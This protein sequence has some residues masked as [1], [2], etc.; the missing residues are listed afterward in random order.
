MEWKDSLLSTMPYSAAVA[1]YGLMP[2]GPTRG[3][4]EEGTPG[5]GLWKKCLVKRDLLAE[6]RL[7]IPLTLE[8]IRP[9]HVCN[10]PSKSDSGQQFLTPP[11][12]MRRV[13]SRTRTG[14]SIPAL[15]RLGRQVT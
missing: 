13:R 9:F 1:G 14:T 4:F 2:I 12:M 3:M 8:L 10:R 15:T 7:Y 11:L 5:S 6:S